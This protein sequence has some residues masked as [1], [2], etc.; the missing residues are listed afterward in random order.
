MAHDPNDPEDPR[1]HAQE[2]G[3]RGNK[4]LMRDSTGKERVVEIDHKG[5][6]RGDYLQPNFDKS[7]FIE[8]YGWHPNESNSSIKSY[9]ARKGLLRQYNPKEE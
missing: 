5:I 2:I 4:V 8:K 3:R 6:K 9:L 7:A 1:N